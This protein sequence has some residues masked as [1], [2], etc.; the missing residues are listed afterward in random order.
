MDENT[1]KEYIKKL[2]L[3]NELINENLDDEETP[4]ADVME[5][6]QGVF[7]ALNKDVMASMGNEGLSAEIPVK[8]KKLRPDAVIPTYAKDGDAGMDLTVTHIISETDQKINYG[9]GL[10]FEIPRGYVG[11]LFPR[12]SIRNYDLV[13]SNCVGVIDSGYRG[14]IQTT[15]KKT[16][17]SYGD[18]AK[19][20]VGDRGAQIVIIPYPRVKFIE[21]SEL[22]D[23]ERNDGGFGST[24]K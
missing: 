7:S 5:S 1:I 9:Y 8:I 2:E 11:L 6:L 4:S 18:H 10:A 23:S 12:S 13:L 19:Y 21:A 14:E 16:P 20:L 15:F 17:Y 3:L 22:S 24:G